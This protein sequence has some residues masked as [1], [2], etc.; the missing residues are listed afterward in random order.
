[1]GSAESDEV[2]MLTT[3]INIS[4]LMTDDLFAAATLSSAME[5]HP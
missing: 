4:Q 1:V 5:L 3:N 2:E